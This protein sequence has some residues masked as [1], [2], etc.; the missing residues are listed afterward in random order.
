MNMATMIDKNK[1]SQIVYR[2]N[3][4]NYILTLLVNSRKTWWYLLTSQ[5]PFG[6]Q[7]KKDFL[8]VR[9]VVSTCLYSP[10]HVSNKISIFYSFFFKLKNVQ[11]TSFDK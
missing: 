6:K 1:W 4:A 9:L 8:K 5:I 7:Q 10:V 2:V 11:C 3:K